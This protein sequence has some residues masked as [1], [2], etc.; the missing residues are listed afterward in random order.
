[1]SRRP[2]LLLVRILWL[3]GLAAAVAIAQPASFLDLSGV[4]P[5]A[6]AVRW[7]YGHD[8]DG[9]FGLPVAGGH[10]CDGD[11]L[12]D[13]AVGYMT[14]S[15]FARDMAGEIYLAFGDGTT[16]G[17]VDSGVDEPTLLRIAGAGPRETAGNEVWIDDVTGD[18]IGDLLICRQNYRPSAARSGAGALTILAG[19][20]ELRTW[21]ETL[22]T[23]DLLAPPAELTLTTFVGANAVDR[24][25]IWTRTG[26]VT[27]DGIA[28]VVVGADQEDGRGRNSG[29]VYVIRGG[30]H[31]AIGGVID[32]RDFGSTVLAGHLARITPPPGSAGYHFGAT[33]QIGDLDGNGRAEVLAAAALA[34]S[35][36]SLRADGAPSGSA[37]PSGGAPDGR[38]YILWDDNFPSGD[39]DAGFSFDVSASPGSRTVI[40]GEAVN[41]RFGEEIL[42]GRDYDLDGRA[43]LFVGDL[44]GDGTPGQDRP[45]SGYGHVFFDAARLRDLEFVADAPPVPLAVTRILGPSQGAIGA[46]TAADGDFD[47]DGADDLAVASPVDSPHGRLSAGTIH[48]LFG[49]PGGWP[50]VIDLLP[51]HLPPPSRLRI[52]EIHGAHG[53]A[54][55][56]AGDTLGYSAAAG[57]LDHDGRTD[58]IT[59]EMVGNGLQPGTDDVGN[60]LVVNG[61]TLA[62]RT[63]G[64]PAV[65]VKTPEDP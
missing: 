33:C 25:C 61:L 12:A 18:G 5:E 36:A 47:G 51:A 58:L 53:R 56:D 34:R 39:W 26:D 7:I 10:D 6:G 52:S 60:L 30:G 42:A 46:D 14:A 23:V 21:A 57:D 1:M 2:H 16:G 54:G 49:R 43:D 29:A 65:L 32:L 9:R 17:F 41:V 35:G 31:L 4:V 28:D 40:R 55:G 45:T 48:V 62:G 15:P 20:G 11:G 37:E 64:G 63:F 3:A 22:E 50:A 44:L 24:L 59:N 27:G 13:L 8:G 38:L 19:G